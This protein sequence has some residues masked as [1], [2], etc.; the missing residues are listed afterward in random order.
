MAAIFQLIEIKNERDSSR[1]SVS[2]GIQ[3]RV[4]E[5]VGTLP[6]TAE[7][8]SVGAFANEVKALQKEL[9]DALGKARALFEGKSS[10]EGSEISGDMTPEQVWAVLS[11]ISGEDAFVETFNGMAE[12][13]RRE[14]AEYILTSCNI[15]AGKAAV[16]SAR[17]DSDAALLE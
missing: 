1:K 3:V 13:R 11:A 16:F 10:G 17:Y 5:Q 7:C 12:E 4:G 6:I 15:F 8:G 14:V 2:L 9:E